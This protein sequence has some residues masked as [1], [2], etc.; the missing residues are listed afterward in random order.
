MSNDLNALSQTMLP[1]LETEMRQVLNHKESPPHLFY[2][3]MHYHMGWRDEQMQP[4]IVNSGKQIRPVIC[5]LA[6][7]AA[8]Q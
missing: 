7:Q 4:A 2:G 8:G 6:C 3:M 5:L 1:A